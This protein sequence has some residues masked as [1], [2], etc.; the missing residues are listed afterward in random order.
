MADTDATLKVKVETTSDTKGIDDVTAKL[1]EL[2]SAGVEL[3]EGL[4]AGLGLAVAAAVATVANEFVKLGQQVTE[5]EKTLKSANDRVN[6]QNAALQ[7]SALLVTRYSDALRVG[8]QGMRNVEQAAKQLKDAQDRLAE[9]PSFTQKLIELGAQ[10][11]T[12]SSIATPFTN[13]LYNQAA[14]FEKLDRDARVATLAIFDFAE[15]EAAAMES[16]RSGAVVIA[17]A[18]TMEK[19]REL[20]EELPLDPKKSDAELKHYIEVK[21]QIAEQEKFLG[22]M[23]RKQNTQRDLVKETGDQIRINNAAGNIGLQIDERVNQAY[24]QRLKLLNDHGIKG[25]EAEDL[26]RKYAD[27]VRHSLESTQALRGAQQDFNALLRETNALIESLRQKQ[28]LIKAAPF[29]GADEKSAALLSLYRQQLDAIAAAITTMRARMAGGSLDPAELARADAIVQKLVADYKKVQ[30]EVDA[31]NK[32]IKAHLQ[33]WVNSW[34]DASTQ[35]AKT[36]ED[37]IGQALEGLN[38]WIVTGKFNLQSMMQSIEML[39][40]KL[41]EQLIMQRVMAAINRT[42]ATSEAAIMGPAIASALAP[43]ATAATVSSFGEAAFAAPAEYAAAL[44][45]IQAL[46]VAHTGGEIAF[47]HN[48]GLAD[49]DVP[50]IAQTGEIVIRRDVAQAHRDFLLALNDAVPTH[51]PAAH[52]SGN[53]I[54]RGG[55]GG[56]AGGGG[57][58][59]FIGVSGFGSQTGTGAGAGSGNLYGRLYMKHGG[60]EIGRYHNGGSVGGGG[61]N[62]YAFTDLKALTR[63]MAS[64]DGQKIIFDTIRG[65]RINLGLR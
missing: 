62:I 64:R 20:H 38:Q 46:A 24:D 42:E 4:A 11:V 7:Q 9:G 40:L 1:D 60:G 21:A 61:I 45:E 56:I 17:I 47:A 59:S 27:S 34:G 65:N 25:R 36:I 30:L 29:L 57:G 26:A 14:A 43:A 10:M 31:I 50:I 49:D 44:F 18:Q 63:H 41:I 12:A 32:P 13:V 2:K 52:L 16:L 15:K 37:T 54:R 55:G 48:G 28:E 35:I 53:R 51:I 23:I 22:E 5:F 33:E 39:G 58:G 6:D 19:L 3:G 8:E